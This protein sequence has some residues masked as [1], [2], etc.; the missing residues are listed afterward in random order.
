M[1]KGG[2]KE[3]DFFIPRPDKIHWNW[4]VKVAL[5][6]DRT[7]LQI[8]WQS[9]GVQQSALDFISI[10]LTKVSDST[11]WLDWLS[12]DQWAKSS[13]ADIDG[14]MVHNTKREGPALA[15]L[16]EGDK[17]TLSVQAKA[18]AEW[19]S[20][21]IRTTDIVFDTIILLNTNLND[22]FITDQV[23]NDLLHP[24]DILS[25]KSVTEDKLV[26]LMI[27][28]KNSIVSPQIKPA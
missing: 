26:H 21:V 11:K 9:G 8:D 4:P 6:K 24:S 18:R 23:C 22:L 17:L 28:L 2:E 1:I 16:A 25:I 5:N 19:N 15:E 10:A 12:Y 27:E 7:E 20:H 13:N 14:I 3:L